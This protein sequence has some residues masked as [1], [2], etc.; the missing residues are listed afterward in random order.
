MDLSFFLDQDILHS[1]K[2]FFEDILGL[3]IAQPAKSEISVKEFLKEQLTD[4][5]LLDK[6][7]EAR[8]IGMIN[9]KSIVG[10]E[11]IEEVDN[12]FENHTDDYDMLLVFGMELK[13][14]I[15]PS[16]SDISR[17]TRAVNR[18]SASR[19]VVLL[20][21]YSNKLTFSAAERGQ[22]QKKGQKVEKIGRISILRDVELAYDKVHAGHERILL[23]LRINPLK[24]TNFKE[25]YD[26][27]LEVFNISI[28]N[29]DF[30][31]ELFTWYLWATRTVTFPKKGISDKDSNVYT[32]E[33]VIRLLTRLI[34]VWFVKEKRLIPESLFSRQFLTT[35]IKNF[36]PVSTTNSDYYKAILQNLFFA[37]L[38]TEMPKDGG[39]RQFLDDA[40]RNTKTG[41]TDE[42]LDHLAYRYKELFIDPDNGLKLFEDVPF[43]NGGLF[44]CL[45][46]RD[47]ETDEEIRIDGFSSKEKNQ[48]VVPN[49]LFWGSV[50]DL[51]LSNEFEDGNKHK[52]SRVRGIISILNSYKFTIE[53]NTPLEQEI[54]L[55]PELLGKIFENLL[56]SYNP[57][58]RSSARKQTGSFYTPREIVNYMVDESLIAYLKAKLTEQVKAFQQLGNS[59]TNLLGNEYKTGQLDIQ[60][61]IAINKWQNREIE[62]E[63][64]LHELFSYEYEGNPFINDQPTTSA[65]IA[66]LG[67]CKILDPACGSGAFPM[68]ILHKLVFALGKLDPFNYTW[69]QAQLEKAIR[70][71]KRAEK[72]EDETLREEAL[73]RSEEKIKYIETSFGKT[74]H[75]LDY[76]RKLFLIEN[77]IYGVDIQQIAIQIS[78][79]RFFIS[80]MVDQRTD[81]SKPNRNILSLPNLE[82][83]F[84][85]A[86]TLI[87]VERPEQGTLISMD[88]NVKRIESELHE[89]RQKIFFTRKWNDKKRLKSQEYS[90]RQELKKALITSGFPTSSAGQIASWDPFAPMLSGSF[91]DPEIMFALEGNNA[92]GFFDI[93]IG[94]PPYIS[95]QRLDLQS[96][97]KFQSLNYLT[98][99]P[100]GD[101]YLLFYE[102]GSKL[103]LNKGILAFITS[104]QWMQASY[105]KSLRK[106]LSNQTNPLQL[107]DFGQRKIFEGTTVFVNILILNKSENQNLLKAC[108]IPLDFN[109]EQGDLSTFFS[110][111]QQF[112]SGLSESTWFITNTK[113]INEQIEKIGIPLKNWKEVE[114]YAGIKTA[115]NDAY[116]IQEWQRQDLITRDHRNIE[117]IKPLLRGKDIKRYNYDFDN[118]YMLNVHNGIRD[119]G[120]PRIDVTK[121]YPIIYKHLKQWQS[122]LETRLDKGE[123]WTNL[124]NCAFFEEFEK[125]KIVWIEIS[126]RANYAYDEN[127]MYLTNSAYFLT[128][129]SDNVSL[130]YLLAV[131]NSKVA[132]FY[133]SQKTA[134][135]AGGR[136]RYTKQYV[137]Q[138]PIPN[139]PPYQQKPFV[140]LVDIIL[141]LKKLQLEDS[142]DKI[143]SFFF[144]RVV[145]VA[146]AELFFKEQ[147]NKENF[148]VIEHLKNEPFLIE[149]KTLKEIRS[150]YNDFNSPNHP[151]RH[152]V[153]HLKNY[154]PM[155]TIEEQLDRKGL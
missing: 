76:A 71:R 153:E 124:R 46:R 99:E 25:L 120:I 85:A 109:L 80:L 93:M 64:K 142:T 96:K 136:M 132:D 131:L 37:T 141:T 23:Q 66:H 102:R 75:E 139:I 112:V 45:D 39:S 17:L 87:P 16:K 126:D 105:G 41:Y 68:G 48:P 145:D 8:F 58:T 147:I 44:E 152:A 151:I 9:D 22:A 19:P 21:K 28:L 97:K 12:F 129:K 40:K 1:G 69:K 15:I 150:I 146:V 55:D 29:K 26:Q 89:I 108:L 114:F 79:L 13:E 43:L 60:I 53:E 50:D 104:R 90:K 83:K 119:L 62:L 3:T 10:K 36:N 125:P 116:H 115:L 118:W 47:P 100:T 51:D 78:K 121:D 73:A 117:I 135:I 144:E 94:N 32:S 133:F 4:E 91:F 140:S 38:N 59:Q 35:I 27:W 24:V 49:V 33:S 154:E 77:C 72:F 138:I 123:H 84:V 52:H 149:G 65:I 130:K 20:T 67:E 74:G 11:Q 31:N 63:N 82:T 86:N 92:G 14:G 106:F 107:I 111:N 61:D 42:Y 6:V 101:I 103:L 70:D 110:E 143:M 134:R 57:E 54:A 2:Q 88:L 18:R 81:E 148:T 127:G 137:E 113:N 155:K 7:S 128:C 30:Y 95:I 98:F 5:A 34:F 122:Q 56:A